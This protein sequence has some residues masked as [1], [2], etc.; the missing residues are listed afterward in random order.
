M[1]A[2]DR[3]IAAGIDPDSAVD[4]AVWYIQQG[5][6]DALE[7]YVLEVEARVCAIQP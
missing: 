2:I 6:D 5:S 4:A 7:R 3:L 1:W